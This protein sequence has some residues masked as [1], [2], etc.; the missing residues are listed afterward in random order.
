MLTR[1]HLPVQCEHSKL[2][3]AKD[4][5]RH[6]HHLPGGF[7]FI[8]YSQFYRA[9]YT[10]NV[11]MQVSRTQFYVLQVALLIVVLAVIGLVVFFAT[12]IAPTGSDLTAVERKLQVDRMFATAGVYRGRMGD[13]RGVC[14]SIGES[15]YV[16]CTE[17][18]TTVSLEATLPDGT[19]YCVDNEGFSGERP[20]SRGAAV[21]CQ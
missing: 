10:T 11:T 5:W 9:R 14:E 19:Y 13:Y 3:G 8:K 18:D 21:S 12:N 4:I 17:G 15:P 2:D 16:T 20:V 7:L 1:H 6:L